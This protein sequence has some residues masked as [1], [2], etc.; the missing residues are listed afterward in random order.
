MFSLL[1]TAL[2]QQ[3]PQLRCKNSERRLVV[4]AFK[5]PFF[6]TFDMKLCGAISLGS[7]KLVDHL[8]WGN[9]TTKPF[10]ASARLLTSQVQLKLSLTYWVMSSPENPL[11]TNIFC[12][13]L[14]GYF[15]LSNSLIAPAL[16]PIFTEHTIA[17]KTNP[18]VSNMMNRLRPLTFL[19]PSIPR[20]PALSMVLT[21]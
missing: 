7:R 15:K 2:I 3:L 21:L 19:P 8:N 14:S 4:S 1:L 6:S 10:C 16:S 20:L 9:S 5:N 13:R 12:N 17:R 11:S 18:N